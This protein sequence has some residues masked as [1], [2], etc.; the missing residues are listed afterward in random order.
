MSNTNNSPD[1]LGKKI[2][3]LHPSAA[4]QNEIITELIQQEYEVYIVKD[5]TALIKVLK[6]YP[7]AI[8][9][10][11]IDEGMG[12]KDWEAW[13]RGL[14]DNP[15]TS[16]ICVGILSVNGDEVLQ[17]KYINSVKVQ[18][19]YTVLKA[20]MNSVIKQLA[21]ILKALDAKGRRKYI[22]ATTENESLTTVNLPVNGTFVNGTIKDISVVGFSCCF[23]EDPDLT[24]NSLFQ[25]IQI[26]LQTMLLKAEG[27]IF[28]SRMDGTAKIYVVL[29]TQRID[30]DARARIRKYIQQ[31]L[32]AKINAELK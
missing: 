23:A 4:V 19:G 31:N 13:I 29:F 7:N 27:I 15:E 10:A 3:F 28:G 6:H 1:I 30:P 20:D 26:K 8:V 16:Q 25:N 11:D 22:R 32:Q 12:E 24:K 5:Q 2:F 18:G 9:F 17:R 21:D 14:L